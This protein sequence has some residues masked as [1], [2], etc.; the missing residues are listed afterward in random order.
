LKHLL[1]AG[2]SF[3][4]PRETQDKHHEI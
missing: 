2:Q 1:T 4:L 3:E